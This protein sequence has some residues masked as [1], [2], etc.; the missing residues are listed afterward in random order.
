VR[1]VAGVVTLEGDVIGDGDGPADLERRPPGYVDN[2][3]RRAGAERG[4]QDLRSVLD[5]CRVRPGVFDYVYPICAAG[6]QRPSLKGRE[7]KR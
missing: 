3:S 4:I 2:T 7:G 1:R 5:S 6:C